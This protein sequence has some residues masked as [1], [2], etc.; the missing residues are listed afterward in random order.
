MEKIT[1]NTNADF[2]PAGKRTAR[3]V[4]HAMSGKKHRRV[5]RCYVAGKAYM[6]RELSDFET[7]NKW[8]AA[9]P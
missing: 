1:I 8:L 9:T 2:T 3:I 4:R 6:Q 7:V 5:I